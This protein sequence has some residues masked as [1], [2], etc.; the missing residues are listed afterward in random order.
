M[1]SS[2]MTWIVCEKVITGWI[3]LPTLNTCGFDGDIWRVWLKYGY[4][5]L[6][7]EM[8]GESNENAWY[9]DEVFEHTRKKERNIDEEDKWKYWNLEQ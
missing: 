1:K 7:V 9:V 8:N 6:I 4:D 5:G 3:T 2:C